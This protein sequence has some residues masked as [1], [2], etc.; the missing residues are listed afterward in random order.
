MVAVLL[1]K[2][3]KD[4]LQVNTKLLNKQP[5]DT[6]QVNTNNLALSNH[7]YIGTGCMESNLV[8]PLP[9]KDTLMVTKVS[10]QILPLATNHIK[11]PPHPVNTPPLHTH[12][13][14]SNTTLRHQIVINSGSPPI[15]LMPPRPLLATTMYP[16]PAT[17]PCAHR[18]VIVNGRDT[19]LALSPTPTKTPLTS[20]WIMA[21]IRYFSIPS[22]PPL[23]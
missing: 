15:N 18:L 11:M 23:G 14:N 2:R 16:L 4:T 8:L 9:P 13:V 19:R 22:L 6:L 10:R 5:K 17:P 7:R 12:K 21:A 1:N 20:S 3:P